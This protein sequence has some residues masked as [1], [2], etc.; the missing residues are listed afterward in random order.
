[1]INI[2]L[3]LLGVLGSGMYALAM[4]PA[5][6]RFSAKTDPILFN[7]CI[8][9]V[10]ALCA[11]TAFA[12]RGSAPLPTSGMLWAAVFGVIFAI[13]VFSNLLALDYG[14]LSL[15]TL[16][17]NFSLVV[18]LLYSAFFFQEK[19]TLLRL[20]GIGILAVC[21]F[22]YTNPRVLGGDKP[23]GG[24]TWKW[25]ALCMTA[26][27]CNGMLGII[28][29]T[30]AVNTDNA[31]ADSFLAWGYLFA[32]VT[33]LV[34]FAAQYCRQPKETRKP[35]RTFF[36]PVMI[37]L[38]CLVGFSN[39]ILNLI[40]VTLATRM[41]AAIVYPVIQ[42]GGPIIVTLGSRLIFGEKISAVKGLAIVLGCAA[43][44]LLNL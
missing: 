29:K 11:F 35:M 17:V 36:V 4:K 24:S 5:N 23:K 15:T 41:D 19:M 34:I 30:Y 14:P 43:I 27:F 22:L 25:L 10:A 16:I 38:M 44:V 39:Y 9:L 2:L 6:L 32:T 3:L 1:M 8:T 31:Y 13:T 28:Q 26:F 37:G 18:T 42:G 33:S 7:G 40:V 20:A 12:I 21:M